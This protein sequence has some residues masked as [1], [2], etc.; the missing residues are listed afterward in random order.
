MY[1]S[2][3]HDLANLAMWQD[4][5]FQSL[6]PGAD[7]LLHFRREDLILLLVCSSWLGL[8]WKW[9]TS[10]VSGSISQIYHNTFRIHK[11]IEILCWPGVGQQFGNYSRIKVNLLLEFREGR[12][13]WDTAVLLEFGDFGTVKTPP[14]Q[15]GL[16]KIL[17]I[18]IENLFS[19][20][21]CGDHIF[22][23]LLMLNVLIFSHSSPCLQLLC[24]C[25][26]S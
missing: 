15:N 12:F 10:T 11:E 17:N 14:G 13:C 24:F 4:S 6:F 8:T 3:H 23:S 22:P 20:F 16:F 7:Y 26:G 1:Q 19:C 9:S 2:C 25:S 5:T 18:L 21:L